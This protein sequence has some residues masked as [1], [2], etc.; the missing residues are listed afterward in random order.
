MKL[1]VGTRKQP[2]LVSTPPVQRP[3]PLAEQQTW[4]AELVVVVAVAV[5]DAMEK[6]DLH[7][8]TSRLRTAPIDFVLTGSI[9]PG[10]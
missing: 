10:L 8:D 4:L 3:V 5:A 9:P 6:D 1:M 2:L 7:Q